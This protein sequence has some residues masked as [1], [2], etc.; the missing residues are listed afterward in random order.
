MNHIETTNYFV[1]ET[2]VIESKKEGVGVV[3]LGEGTFE[4]GQA[5]KFDSTSM[6]LVKTTTG[7]GIVRI[8]L[9]AGDATSADV[10]ALMLIEGTVNGFELKGVDYIVSE[11]EMETPDAPTSAL[12]AGGTLTA[13]THEYKVVA[14]NA[15]GKT[16]PSAASTAVTTHVA[17]AG[18][19]TSENAYTNIAAVNAILGNCSATNK[20]TILNVDGVITTILWN[21]DYSGAGALANW[22]ALIAKLDTA[23][24]TTS[25]S[26]A[27]KIVI[28]SDTT[29]ASSKVTVVL[30]E[31]GI[32]GTPV[33]V[34]GKAIEKKVK[35]T[36][37]EVTGSTGFTAWRSV[38]SATYTYRVATAAEVG[39]G[40]FEDDGT[41]TWASGTAVTATDFATLQLAENHGIYV[42]EVISGYEFRKV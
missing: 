32:M 40:Y 33:E 9:E 25:G 42:Q 2:L 11:N 8:A 16:A 17:T 5:F 37:P 29:G 24:S 20:R 4:K 13:A 15:N 34:A 14:T 28:T 27:N 23:G 12:Q 31:V 41:L 18:T 35:V 6:K 21:A 10:S 3:K 26:D 36:F 30:D 22:A 39:Q 38:G 7:A 19:A 1:D